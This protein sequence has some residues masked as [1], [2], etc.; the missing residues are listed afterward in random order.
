MI[1]F[2]PL[3]L[4]LML[5]ALLI[6]LIAQILLSLWSKKYLAVPNTTNLTGY[7]TAH[8]VAQR[9]N[10]SISLGQ[11]PKDLDDHYDPSKNELVL[12]GAVAQ[13][14]TIGAVAITAHELGHAMQDQSNNILLKLRT[15]I[16][17][18][19]NIGTN[20]GYILIV[21]GL[22]IAVSQLAW[23]GVAFFSASVLF[24]FLTLPIEIDASSRAIKVIKEQGL[25][26]RTEIGNAKK[27][28]AAASL[29]YT[30]AAVS[31]LANLV[32]F[33]LRVRGI[34]DD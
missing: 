31:S 9:Y 32:Y 7:D 6:S 12:S 28:L 29:T 11:T 5:P 19:V 33:A 30:A 20:L 1:Y 23:I 18:M 26:G 10:L 2:D 13:K 25:L 14:P 21:I 3:Y 4:I 24:S 34:D 17:P 27:V 15:I 22:L 16:V 8:I